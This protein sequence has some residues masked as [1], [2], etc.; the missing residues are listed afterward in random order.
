MI[1]RNRGTRWFKYSLAALGLAIF[2][3]ATATPSFGQ[4]VIIDNDFVNGNPLSGAG[5]LESAFYTTSSGSGLASDNGTPG[6]LDFASGTSGRVYSLAVRRANAVQ[7]A[8]DTLTLSY[9]FTTPDTVGTNEDFRVGLFNTGGAAGFNED[10]SAS[11]GT[12][13]P[14]LKRL[15]WH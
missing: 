3:V 9:S 2:S 10:I 4:T 13:N 5:P 15:G 12:P 1:I 8:G 14:I 6:V 7:H 11:S